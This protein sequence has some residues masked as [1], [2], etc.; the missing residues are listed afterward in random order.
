[1]KLKAEHLAGKIA[2][3]EAFFKAF[4]MKPRWLDLEVKETSSGKP[5]LIVYTV[6]IDKIEKMDYSI[7]H[8]GDYAVAQVVVLMKK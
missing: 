5:K 6:L 8:D 3:K 4:E 7:S 2:L 1:M